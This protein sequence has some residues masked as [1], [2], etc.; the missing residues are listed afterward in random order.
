LVSTGAFLTGSGILDP[1]LARADLLAGM[2]SER[3]SLLTGV[4][5]ELLNAIA[6]VG[7]ALLLQPTLRK[8]HEA[9]AYGYVASR[10]MEAAVLPISIAGPLISLASSEQPASAG[11][12]SW[13][14]LG[15]MAV[16]AHYLSCDLA[17]L[18]LSIGSLFLCGIRYRA[19]LVPR[20]LSIIGLI[21]YACPLAT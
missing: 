3:T 20:M 16:A 11:E 17:M 5:L 4:F 8:Y 21:G 15:Q 10:V 1:I 18:V 2:D 19:R 13:Q 9:H 7:I 14:V 12:A 6:A